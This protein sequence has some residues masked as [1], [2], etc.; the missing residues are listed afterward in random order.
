MNQIAIRYGGFMGLA[1]VL[2][3]LLLYL[4]SVNTFFSFS[5]IV[6]FIVYIGFMVKAGL[7]ERMELGGFM[8]FGEA[9]RVT[10]QVFVIGSFVK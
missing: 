4:I 9:F 3:N 1:L 7:D 8:S 10:F 6:G 5:S 2:I